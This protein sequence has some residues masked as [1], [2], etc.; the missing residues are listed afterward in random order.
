[1]AATEE[2]ERLL[3]TFDPP[4]STYLCTGKKAGTGGVSKRPW[5]RRSGH[6]LMDTDEGEAKTREEGEHDRCAVEKR[7][8][9]CYM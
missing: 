6:N 7:L 4:A 1:M 3:G 2:K 9:S 8:D 5:A